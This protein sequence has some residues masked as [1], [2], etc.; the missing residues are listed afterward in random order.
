MK[1]SCKVAESNDIETVLS[2]LKQQFDSQISDASAVF[3]FYGCHHQ[4][5]PIQ[6]FLCEKFPNAAL[7]GG[8]SSGGVMS[9]NGIG[10]N[11]SV[12]LFII[13]D[14]DG[15]YG[16]ASCALGD[17]PAKAA[18]TALHVA[19]KNA[20]CE[21]QVPDLIW[22]YQ[23]P[24]NEEL[25]LEGLHRVVGDQ[26]PIIGGSSADDD[27]SGKWSQICGDAS[28][29][30]RIVIA[31]LF[32]STGVS[33]AFQGGYEP[34]ECSG[35]VT[36]TKGGKTSRSILEIDGKPAAQIYNSWTNNSIASQLENGGNILA[37]TTMMPLGI[38]TD[39]IEGISQYLLIHP[40]AVEPDGTLLT[41]GN[42][43]EGQSIT[44]M[45]GETKQL[46]ARAGGVVKQAV[47]QFDN[48]KPAAAIIVFCAGCRMAVEE[49]IV[50]VPPQISASL[51]DVPF[52]GCFT[53]GEQGNLMGQNQHGN[54]MISAIV[55]GSRK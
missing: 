35:V 27:V 53:F 33:F 37:D 50:Q 26:C 7:I 52:L 8:S 45:K 16:A 22:V 23:P 30:D 4:P 43:T 31:V 29:T 20:D 42:V 17:D 14:E 15:D 13:E 11:N 40:E 49:N 55:F 36:A 25:T 44:C 38:E 28:G 41:F 51:G 6:N 21:G 18:E 32:P 5:D 12:G 24:G 10:A 19:L 2:E 9:N 46:I 47:E 39:E 34:T 1:V 48:Q 54:L 3:A